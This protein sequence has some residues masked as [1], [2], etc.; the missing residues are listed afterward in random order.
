MVRAHRVLD[1]G[2]APLW[3]IDPA[4]AGRVGV[5]AR[6]EVDALLG[7]RLVGAGGAAEGGVGEPV[8]LL[9]ARHDAVARA[10]GPLALLLHLLVVRRR[11]AALFLGIGL[12]V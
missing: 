1:V 11:S 7:G 10:L 12:H 4:V 5:V 8:G 9:V 2:L 3:Q 6:A